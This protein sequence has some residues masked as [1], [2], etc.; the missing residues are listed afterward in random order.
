MIHQR[1]IIILLSFMTCSLHGQTNLNASLKAGLLHGYLH[2][3][4]KDVSTYDISSYEDEPNFNFSMGASIQMKDKFRLGAEFGLTSYRHFFIYNFNRKDGVTE[5]YDGLYRIQQASLSIV[6][7]YRLLKW[8]Y[9]NAG[10]GLYWDYNSYFTSGT[11]NINTGM[12]EII[13]GY[14]LKRAYP[15]GY[16]VGMGI[17]PNISKELAVLGEVRFT[18]SPATINSPEDVGIGYQAFNFNIGLMYKPRL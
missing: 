11:R 9:L 17:C 16:F 7:E 1:F 6:P 8:F 18:G 12:P 15:I 5:R 2:M 10:T 13:N 4:S 3:Q 14:S